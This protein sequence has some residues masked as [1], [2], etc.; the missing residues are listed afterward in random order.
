MDTYLIIFIMIVMLFF[1]IP[2]GVKQFIVTD[3][4]FSNSYSNVQCK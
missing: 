4:K 2:Y 1:I 3:D